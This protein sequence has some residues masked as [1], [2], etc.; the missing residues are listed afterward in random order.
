[1]LSLP[2]SDMHDDIAKRLMTVAA[3]AISILA[4]PILARAETD[5]PEI[6]ITVNS[7]ADARDA[8]PGNGACETAAGN[9]ICTLRAAVMEA[10]ATTSADTIMLPAGIY[11]LTLTGADDTAFSGDLD[12]SKSATLIGAGVNET[13]V[14]AGGDL[15]QDRA[16]EV[17]PQVSVNMYDFTIR[18]GKPAAALDNNQGKGGG[19]LSDRGFL[20]LYRMNIR[21]NETQ[22]DGGG[23]YAEA[24]SLGIWDTTLQF[25]RASSGGALFLQ[26]GPTFNSAAIAGS[27]FLHNTAVAGSGGGMHVAS[28]MRVTIANTTFNSNGAH[29]TGGGLHVY[30]AL[31]HL[32]NVTIADN[33][34]NG[35]VVDT[36][37]PTGGGISA[38]GATPGWE[39]HLRNSIIA[40]NKSVKTGVG[41]IDDD[42]VGA[43]I[44]GGFNLIEAM[45]PSCGFL[46]GG[47][48]SGNLFGAD[49]QLLP[50]ADNGGPTRTR[51][52]RAT[53]P[54]RS[55]AIDAGN[56]VSCT[57]Q[58]GTPY[59]TDQRGHGRPAGGRCDIGAYEHDGAPPP[60][61]APTP[62]PTPTLPTPSITYTV[63][64]PLIVR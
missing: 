32:N 54:D 11:T 19:I 50:L 40:D 34:S 39:V 13:I 62:T 38:L 1:M 16:F 7:S 47:N 10:N 26:P 14:A 21:G 56:L 52:L 36:D 42:C 4:L 17:L 57:D 33:T 31:V 2:R 64:L 5:V 55:P 28:G 37:G 58:A 23:V 29:T 51:A 18:G 22:G 60:G 20:L 61:P 49:P 63:N 45:P 46:Q 30:G 48:P 27:L 25:N 8:N 43:M 3:L 44:S 41:L 15:T 35:A 12:F 6:T 24:G 59:A 53:Q 9:G